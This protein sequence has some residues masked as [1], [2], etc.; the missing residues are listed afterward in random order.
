VRRRRGTHYR[1]KPQ[2]ARDEFSVDRGDRIVWF[3]ARA[4]RGAGPNHIAG[5]MVTLRVR[6]G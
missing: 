3:P 4:H 6:M 1:L 2:Q 5:R